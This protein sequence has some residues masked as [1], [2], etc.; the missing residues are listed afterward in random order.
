MS[1]LQIWRQKLTNKQ[2][3]GVNKFE[4]KNYLFIFKKLL[5]LNQIVPYALEQKPATYNKQMQVFYL[6]QHKQI[7]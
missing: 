3:K 2:Q 6:K 4:R 1:L 7:M 5:A